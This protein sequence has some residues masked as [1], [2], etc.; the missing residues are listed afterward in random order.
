M[1]EYEELEKEIFQL[2]LPRVCRI[3]PEV[4]IIGA[5]QAQLLT[6]EILSIIFKDKKALNPRLMTEEDKIWAGKGWRPVKEIKKEVS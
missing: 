2:I 1:T 4:D 3:R 6:T 5:Q